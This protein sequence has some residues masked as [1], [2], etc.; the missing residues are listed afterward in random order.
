MDAQDNNNTGSRSPSKIEIW[1]AYG[2]AKLMEGVSWL[3]WLV[4]GLFSG[5]GLM[6][7]LYYSLKWL[8][9]GEWQSH[10][11]YYY[12]LRNG[13]SWSWLDH[14]TDWLGIWQIVTTFLLQPA[15]LVF[16]VVGLPILGISFFMALFFKEMAEDVMELGRKNEKSS[17][18][19]IV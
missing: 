4:G 9:T 18:I 5:G 3:V 15:W 14:P 2:F 19:P 10:S 1:L 6:N 7:L 16:L 8:R 17:S 12:L 13:P 11:A